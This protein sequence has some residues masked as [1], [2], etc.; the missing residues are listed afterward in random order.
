[1]TKRTLIVGDVHGCDDELGAL[2]AE[3]APDDVVLVGDL[4]TKGPKPLETYRRIRGG[5]W[6]SVLGNHDQRLLRVAD[7]KRPRDITGQDCVELLNPEPGWAEW[8]AALPM[9]L[10][11]GGWTIVHAGLAPT[12]QADTTREMAMV[13]RRWPFRS[14]EGA[15]WHEVYEG[16]ERVVFGH[17][18]LRGWVR[19][20]KD[21]QP[22]LIGLD[23]GCVYGGA[24]TGYVLETNEVFTVQA[25][26]RY[27]P[28]GGF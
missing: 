16:P 13:M 18:A 5:G 7:G 28:V 21:G 17:D 14:I 24:L 26:K 19:R 27:C 2:V 3:A 1:M 8:V 22:Y 12:G 23:T 6:R 20:D 10:R 25:A 15:A 4:F 11:V 9:F